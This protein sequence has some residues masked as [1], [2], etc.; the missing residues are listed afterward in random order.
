M[1]AALA[2]PN[3]TASVETRLPDPYRDGPMLRVAL[4]GAIVLHGLALLVPMPARELPLAGLSDLPDDRLAPVPYVPRPQ[5]PPPPE[6]PSAPDVGPRLVPATLPVPSLEPDSERRTIV[7]DLPPVRPM[8][9]TALAGEIEPPP[10][11]AVYDQSTIGLVLPVAFDDRA[12][13]VYPPMGRVAGR[14]GR[15]VLLATISEL[16]EVESIEVLQAPN[17]DLG[18][19]ESAIDAV[20]T[21]RYEPGTLHGRPVSVQMTVVVTYDLS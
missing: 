3:D 15:V 20:S 5:P 12:T 7:D 19:V 2:A 21:W 10:A 14:G 8:Q 13:P 6:S 4:F 17:P 11:P 1:A 16:G 18:F 9:V